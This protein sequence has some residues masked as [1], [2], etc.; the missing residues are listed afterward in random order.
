M[1]NVD[2]SENDIG[3][4]KIEPN[5]DWPCKGGR[6]QWADDLELACRGGLAEQ[7]ASSISYLYLTYSLSTKNLEPA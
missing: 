7:A 2:Q 1:V 6:Q 5:S 4:A 3:D